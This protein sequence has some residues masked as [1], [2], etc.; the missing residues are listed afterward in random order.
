MS[1]CTPDGSCSSGVATA[2]GSEAAD[3]TVTVYEV[4]G[5]T[6]GHCRATLTEQIGAVDGVLAVE[7]DLKAG[8]VAVT[9]SRDLDDELLAKVVDEAGYGLTGRAA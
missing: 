2:D 9:S 7:V 4:S 1:C 5:M 3:G 8:Q 6:Y